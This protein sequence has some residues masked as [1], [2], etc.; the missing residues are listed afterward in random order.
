M[1]LRIRLIVTH[2]L[3]ILKDAYSLE[4]KHL[5]KLNQNTITHIQTERL[6]IHNLDNEYKD[7][8][9]QN[10]LCFSNKNKTRS[11]NATGLII[12]CVWVRS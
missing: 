3:V 2:S 6:I 12:D 1:E 5:I 4:Q 11:R 10:E 7:V 9:L 8:S